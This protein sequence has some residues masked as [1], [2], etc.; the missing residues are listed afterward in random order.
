MEY[1]T[2]R[3]SLI[4]SID[5]WL[6]VVPGDSRPCWW[7]KCLIPQHNG[8]SISQYLVFYNQLYQNLY[9]L[10]TSSMIHRSR[11]TGWCLAGE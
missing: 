3:D 11:T 1:R 8:K 9:S 5:V 4:K 7:L 6:W 2:G 10:S